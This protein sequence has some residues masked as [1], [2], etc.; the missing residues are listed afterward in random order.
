MTSADEEDEED[1]DEGEDGGEDEGEVGGSSWGTETGWAEEGGIEIT[2]R[3][4]RLG[5]GHGCHG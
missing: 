1:E 3:T 5:R 2:V 4:R